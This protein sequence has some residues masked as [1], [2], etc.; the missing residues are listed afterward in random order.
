MCS[1]VISSSLSIDRRSNIIRGVTPLAAYH[2]NIFV[3]HFSRFSLI[4]ERVLLLASSMMSWMSAIGTTFSTALRKAIAPAAL[5][6]TTCISS[7]KVRPSFVVMR[8]CTSVCTAVFD[9]RSWQMACAVIF[10]P[11][12]STIRACA[13]RLPHD[14]ATISAKRT[15]QPSMML[16][17]PSRPARSR[18]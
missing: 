17:L 13:R 18:R 5:P 10:L 4:A 14:W 12:L 6:V 11:S 3:R 7:E 16:F 8:R 1:A 15:E 2:E 9:S